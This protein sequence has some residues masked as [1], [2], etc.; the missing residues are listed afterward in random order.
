MADD[1]IECKTTVR[2]RQE[3]VSCDE[4]QR[5]QHRNCNTGTCTI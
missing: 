2:P 1:C 4:C 3:A 5:W